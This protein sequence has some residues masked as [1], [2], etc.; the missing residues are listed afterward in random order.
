M[1]SKIGLSGN[2][3]IKVKRIK[4]GFA[5]I[6]ALVIRKNDSLVTSVITNRTLSL[7]VRR[8]DSIMMSMIGKANETLSFIR[9]VV[10]SIK[11]K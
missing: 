4:V 2:L 6:I 9:S 5:N 3:G 10:V 8:T 7:T 11:R 1:D